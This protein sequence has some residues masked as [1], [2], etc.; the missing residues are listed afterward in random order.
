MLTYFIALFGLLLMGLSLV[1][2]V[3]PVKWS[4]LIIEFSK[5]VYFH[6]FEIV[7]RLISGLIF[8]YAATETEYAMLIEGIGYLLV[9]VACGLMLTPPSKHR[10]FALWSATKFRSIF[11]LAGLLSFIFGGFLVYVG[12]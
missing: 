11:R 5:K 3:S 12:I 10:Q 2:I 6:A 1:M 9:M 4:V 7:S 8:I